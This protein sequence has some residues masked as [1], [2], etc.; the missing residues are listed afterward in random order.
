MSEQKRHAFVVEGRMALP[1]QYFAGTTG[2]S[3]SSPCETRRRSSAFD[4]RL[5]QDVCS[6]S[7]DL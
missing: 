3:S 4:V 2:S 1:Y 5:Q 7:P 6:A